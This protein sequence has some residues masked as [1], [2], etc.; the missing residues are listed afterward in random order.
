MTGTC[1]PFCSF[2][3]SLIS[4]SYP[5]LLNCIF[6]NKIINYSWKTCFKSFAPP[7]L[8]KSNTALALFWSTILFS[9]MKSPR[10]GIHWLSA[11]QLLP[12]YISHHCYTLMTH[13]WPFQSCKPS[14]Y[15]WTNII[16]S[17][18]ST[19]S[20][21]G[22]LR[23]IEVQYTQKHLCTHTHQDMN[24]KKPNKPG[25]QRSLQ[26]LIREKSTSYILRIGANLTTKGMIRLCQSFTQV[27]LA[28][29]PLYKSI[30]TTPCQVCQKDHLVQFH[31]EG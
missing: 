12:A 28:P 7:N 14:S 23:K 17:V 18:T 21:K 22:K 1:L 4:L 27:H 8:S 5:L 24:Q 19:T 2:L 6:W 29:K 9:F 31:Q 16:L 10:R 3:L 30:K 11:F 25:N 26:H 13:W 20:Y 15:P